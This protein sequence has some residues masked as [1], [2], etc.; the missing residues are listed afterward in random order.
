MVVLMSTNDGDVIKKDQ[1]LHFYH[2]RKSKDPGFYEFKP[3]ERASRLILN[4]PL[5]L[6]NWKPN[7]FF[8]S[9]SGWKFI[10]GE[11]LDEAPKFFRSWRT[12][13]SI[14][15]RPRLKKRY[16]CRAE[17]VNEYLETVKDFDELVSPQF[18]FLHF[19]GPEPSSKV[20]RN[21][22]VVKKRMTTR[23]SKQKLA[24]AREKKAKGGLVSGLLSKKR[25]KVGDVS[26]DDPVVTPPAAHSLAKHPASLTSSLEVTAFVVEE[27]KKKK[28]FGGKSF[29]PSFWDDANA[30]T[31]KAHK[32]LSVD[33]LSPLMSKSSHIQKLVQALGESLFI[34]GKLLD[35]EKR[36]ATSEPM[37]KSLSA[38]NEMLKNKVAILTVEAENDKERAVALEKSLQVEKDFCKLK[39]KQIGFNL[40]KKWM[41]KHHPD[42]DLS[43]LVNGDVEKE[44]LSNH[45]SGA[46]MEN[47]MEEAMTTAEV[48]EEAATITPANPVLDER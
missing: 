20:R 32:A 33:D 23:Y 13:V 31:L 42:L 26:K 5:S 40:L 16:H 34:F 18:M 6:Q 15:Q 12:L 27:T 46:T 9:G 1:F 39:D 25:S 29:L 45:P 17:K 19:L 48:T 41:A 24:E 43:S 14:S 4:Y 47:V 36:V 44:L 37:I 11:D 38:E 3:S 21:L 35:L 22:E 8:V 28:K 10:P 30:A 2:L 7:F